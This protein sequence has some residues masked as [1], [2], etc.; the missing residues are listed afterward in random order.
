M[1]KKIYVT[2]E[3]RWAKLMES[4]RDKGENTTDP[5]VKRK[6]EEVQGQ[7]LLD[8]Y[9]SHDE[10]KKAGVPDKGLIGQLYKTNQ[11]GE[12]FYKCKRGHYN[13]KFKEG[14]RVQGPPKVLKEAEDGSFV[15]WDWQEDGLIGNGSKVKVKFDVWDNKIVTMEAVAVLEH[16]PFESDGNKEGF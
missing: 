5:D 12:E 14:E 2:G 1:G 3:A 8:L 7:Y 15:D 10:V 9:V 4:N 16:V 6:L 11:D 13:P